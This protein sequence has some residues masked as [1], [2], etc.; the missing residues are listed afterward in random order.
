[1]GS[2][3]WGT[4]L[5]ERHEGPGPVEQRCPVPNHGRHAMGVRT[6]QESFLWGPENLHLNGQVQGEKNSD[7]G[8]ATDLPLELQS[9][10]L[11]WLG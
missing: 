11:S 3:Y 2:L 4:H 5:L 6:G 10:D 1:M 9:L 8:Q 7:L